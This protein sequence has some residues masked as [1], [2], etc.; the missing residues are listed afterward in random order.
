MKPE[1]FRHSL[2]NALVVPRPIGWISTIGADCVVNLA[3]FSFFNMCGG[4]PPSVMY[5]ANGTHREGGPKDSLANVREVPE[6]VFNLCTWDLREQMNATSATSPRSVDE[7]AE[8]GLEAATS[9][10]VRPPRV[11][12]TPLAL[13]CEV[14]QIV[15]LP[16]SETTSNNMVI[17]RVVEVHIADHVIVD[18]KVDVP[19]LRPLAR[20]GY[21]DY[22]VID[23]VFSMVRP[24]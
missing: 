20:L 24:A 7:M 12:A 3:P 18:G 8:A 16:S 17:G 13:E 21:L 6:F 11:A 5:C 10:R 19:T 1:G 23:D 15:A 22:S 4:D 2:Y 14:V 9:V